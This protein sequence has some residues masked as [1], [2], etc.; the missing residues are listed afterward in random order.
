MGNI[1]LSP[2]AIHYVPVST[3]YIKVIAKIIGRYLIYSKKRVPKVILIRAI[4]I[5]LFIV[6]LIFIFNP[7]WLHTVWTIFLDFINANQ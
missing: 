4:L 7:E 2:Y 6:V 3:Y 5:L 1:P